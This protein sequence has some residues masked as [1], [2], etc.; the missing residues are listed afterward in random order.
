V[1]RRLGSGTDPG[2]IGI[3]GLSAVQL[4]RRP[5]A[6]PRRG[7]ELVHRAGDVAG[8]LQPEPEPVTGERELAVGLGRHRRGAGRRPAG[9][10]GLAGG[11]GSAGGEQERRRQQAAAADVAPTGYLGLRADTTQELEAM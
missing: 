2:Q 8:F 10:G 7:G 6:E 3:R 4:R 9:A 1:F 5:A 11:L